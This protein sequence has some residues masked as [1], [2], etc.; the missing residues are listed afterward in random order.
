M[1]SKT[2]LDLNGGDYR[3]YNYFPMTVLKVFKPLTGWFHRNASVLIS[4]VTSCANPP[5]NTWKLFHL[6]ELQTWDRSRK[7]Y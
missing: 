7:L 3:V 6:N 1:H 2:K 4:L 5:F